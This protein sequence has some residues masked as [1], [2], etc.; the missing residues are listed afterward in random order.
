MVSRCLADQVMQAISQTYQL[1]NENN[2]GISYGP[3][4]VY[5]G[6]HIC[7]HRDTGDDNNSFWYAISRD[8]YVKNIVSNV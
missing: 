4:D 5:L 2:T 7:K 3:P 6:D 1:K 8:H